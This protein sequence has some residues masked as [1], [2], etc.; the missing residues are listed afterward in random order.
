[1]TKEK[2]KEE[3]LRWLKDKWT[4]VGYFNTQ[5]HRDY[6]MKLFGEDVLTKKYTKQA[7]DLAI[8]KTAEEIFK[9]LY[10]LFPD[11]AH[12]ISLGMIEELKKKW[13][14]N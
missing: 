9:E 12:D 5:A 10:N 3:V 13:L 1:M 4:Y 14:R 2:I 8:Q 7:I 11:E 6:F